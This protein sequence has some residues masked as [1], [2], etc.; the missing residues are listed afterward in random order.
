[1]DLTSTISS[2]SSVTRPIL[3]TECRIV[4]IL[5]FSIFLIFAFLSNAMLLLIFLRHRSN[6]HSASF[7]WISSQLIVANFLA[8]FP[9]AVIV[10]PNM[11]LS[12][13]TGKS[14]YFD[15]LN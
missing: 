1:M 10:L 8:F 14:Y 6:V 12:K 13:E 7:Y 9:Q 15:I 11:I 4:A 3:T 5:L 2:S